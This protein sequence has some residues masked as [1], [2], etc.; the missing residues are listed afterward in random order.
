MRKLPP[1]DTTPMMRDSSRGM[2]VRVTPQ[3]TVM[4]S[5]P[6]SMCIRMES[7]KSSSVSKATS[8]QRTMASYTGT[9]PTGTLEAL[10]IILRMARI[11]P[12]VDRSMTVSA[13]YLT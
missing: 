9:V 7:R 1:R 2:H 3:C 12:P 11:S 8:G 13:P 10:M 5:T 6:S 4:K